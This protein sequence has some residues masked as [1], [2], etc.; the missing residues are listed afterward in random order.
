MVASHR[1]RVRG[2]RVATVVASLAA[3]AFAAVT[4]RSGSVDAATS[5]SS[6]SVTPNG[7]SATWS[8]GPLYGYLAALTGPVPTAACEDPSCEKEDVA[9]N[10]S[11][12]YLAANDVTLTVTVTLNPGPT[13]GGADSWIVDDSG[14]VLASSF[15][16]PAV[17]QV[18]HLQSTHVTVIE[19]GDIGDGVTYTGMAMATAT[20]KTTPVLPRDIAFTP[21]A[22]VSANWLGQ[23]PQV[24]I[25]RAAPGALANAI[26]PRR[27]FVDWPVGSTSNI[28]Q[29]SRS[30]DGGQTFRLVVDP[31]CGVR[32]RPNCLT[33]G[34]G[35]S[36][37]RVNGYDGTLFF[38]D[39][40]SLAAEAEASSIDHGDT[41]PAT[42]Q[43]AVTAGGTGVDR[44]WIA[45]VDAPGMMAGP[46][47]SFELRAV[48]AYHIP[49]VGVYV[50]GI[51]TAGIVHPSL[52]PNFTN[53]GQSG[54]NRVDTTSGP[55][56]GWL[57]QGFRQFSPTG[58]AV[59]TAP[60]SGYQSPTSW[61]QSVVSTDNAD[62][63]PWLTLDTAGN[64]YIGWDVGGIAYYAYS[65]IDDPANN[66]KVGGVP[67]TKWSPKIRINPPVFGSVQFAEIVAGDPGRLGV[68]YL[69]TP[70]FEGDSGVVPPGITANWYTVAA[71]STNALDANGHPTFH[72]GLV[73]DRVMH[74]GPICHFGTTCAA[75]MLDRSLA[76]MIDIAMDS[77]GHVGVVSMD[78]NDG[79]A[80]ADYS[81]GALGSPFVTY[82]RLARGPSLYASHA[83]AGL[84]I[85]A[86]STGAPAGNATWPNISGGTNLPALDLL[87]TRLVTDGVH[88]AGRID[89]ADAS[90]AGMTRDLAAY[91]VT[92]PPGQSA[93]RV[94][95]VLRFDTP[96]DV[97]YMAM[98]QDASGSR[99]FFGGVLGSA[100][101]VSGGTSTKAVT[102]DAQASHPV[103]GTVS[104]DS[105]IFSAKLADLGISPSTP[106]RSVTAFAMAGPAEGSDTLDVNPMR[107]VD[108]TPPFDGLGMTSGAELGHPSATSIPRAPAGSS[109]G[110]ASALPNTGSAS[111]SRAALAAAML[112]LLAIAATSRRRSPRGG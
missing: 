104:G 12:S 26:D 23:E 20:R 16:N 34:G 68:A 24:T 29:L 11:P 9:I 36:I 44:E 43:F 105:L 64:A 47:D 87:G 93:G 88:L 100:N 1:R 31:Q 2:R 80:R 101:A 91:N 17:M 61:H 21:Q 40:E 108:A 57:Y 7:A 71:I 10:A 46:I 89:L 78:N 90:V 110:G 60:L 85:S 25:E 51:D 14:A 112:M 50:S 109:T 52:M 70:S 59:A 45:T 32:S 53:V 49:A 19:N 99:R 86:A 48:Y 82:A 98:D 6:V 39:Q 74:Q 69:G 62:S 76:D 73:S 66:P 83:P 15:A 58:V 54:P 63:F 94:E 33:G 41:F 96:S 81:M 79:L 30:L 35:D 28:S 8:G 42:R 72:T 38:G 56:R 103:T 13:G 106:V 92:A 77:D 102:Y 4:S 3:L 18:S 67:G 22:I 97:V 111:G 37:N 27:V 84:R 5:P 55:G 95:Y 75:D 107:T 65:R